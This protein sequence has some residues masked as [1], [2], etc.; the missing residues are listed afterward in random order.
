MI[1]HQCAFVFLG[2]ENLPAAIWEQWLAQTGIK[3]VN[4]VGCTEVYHNFIS[5]R[6][7]DI[8]PGSSGKAVP[9]F[10][11]KLVDP[12]GNELPD[13]GSGNLMVRGDHHCP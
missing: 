4:G 2:G 6:P 13:G 11:L 12:D 3:I 9:G 8:R 5:N 10:D 1:Y 7:D